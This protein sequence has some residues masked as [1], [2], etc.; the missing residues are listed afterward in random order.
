MAIESGGPLLVRGPVSHRS[1]LVCAGIP[2][3]LHFGRPA[4]GTPTFNPFVYGLDVL[5]PLVNFHQRD[6]WAAEGW[7]ALAEIAFNLIGWT[8]ATAAAVAVTSSLKKD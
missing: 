3:G 1:C 6:S 7:V 2:S 5:L 8:L 4:A